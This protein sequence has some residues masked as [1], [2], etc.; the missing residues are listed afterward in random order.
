MTE[1][2]N[3]TLGPTALSLC[4]QRSIPVLHQRTAISKKEVCGSGT[5]PAPPADRRALLLQAAQDLRA[6][7]LPE[8][9][10]G[11]EAPGAL[12]RISM[13]FHQVLHKRYVGCK[14]AEGKLRNSA[15]RKAYH[16]SRIVSLPSSGRAS[17]TG[18]RV[19]GVRE[20]HYTF[21]LHQSRLRPTNHQRIRVLAFGSQA[22]LGAP[23]LTD[24][25]AITSENMAQQQVTGNAGRGTQASWQHAQGL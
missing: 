16:T 1:A 5:Y 10:R 11:G 4:G 2:S 19:I 6:S 7:A 13:A 21:T 18:R 22:P 23:S 17:Y 3:T 15:A 24:C 9:R 25:L 20:T 14:A 12:Q 8:A